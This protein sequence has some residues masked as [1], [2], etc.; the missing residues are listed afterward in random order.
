MPSTIHSQDVERQVEC[1]VDLGVQT[2]EQKLKNIPSLQERAGQGCFLCLDSY[3]RRPYAIL[4][5]CL[6]PTEARG[7]KERIWT[8]ARSWK[9]VY[10][11]TMPWENACESDEDIYCRL[12]DTCYRHLGWWKRWLPYYGITNVL[13]VNVSMSAL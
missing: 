3:G 2:F 8:D 5:P 6:R 11:D 10:E 7:V 13:E 9:E 12:R 1:Q 4:V